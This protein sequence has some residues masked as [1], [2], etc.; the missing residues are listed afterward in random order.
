VGAR[1]LASITSNG[2]RCVVVSSSI[3]AVLVAISVSV[4]ATRITA[5]TAGDVW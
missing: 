3:T 5:A 2:C 4:S 1:I